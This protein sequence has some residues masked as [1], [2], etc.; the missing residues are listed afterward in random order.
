MAT[1]M[2]ADQLVAA[3]RAEGVRYVEYRSWRTHNRN[4]KGRW[5]PVH[6]VYIHHTAGVSKTMADICYDGYAELPG[7]VCHGMLAKTAQLYLV[8]SGRA[9]HAGGIAQNAFDAALNEEPIHPRPDAAEPIDGNVHF[10]GLEIENEG[11]GTDPFP[12]D[13][14]DQA[15]RWAAAHCRFHGWSADSVIGHK[16]A[17]RRKVDPAFSMSQFRADVAERLS[18]APSWSPGETPDSSEEDDMPT[19]QEIAAAVWDHQLPNLRPNGTPDGTK[20]AA[21][22][23][24]IWQ[25]VFQAQTLQAITDSKLKPA[26]IAAAL[27][28]GTLKVTVTVAPTNTK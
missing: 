15:V 24:L 23:W 12:A 10:Y 11:D 18:H 13:Q 1:P 4:H 20:K 7:P 9:N 25:D 21:Y 26:E 17:T 2:T 19:A 16:E 3:L 28:D 5:G 14:Y 27:A 8:G 22:W 6:G